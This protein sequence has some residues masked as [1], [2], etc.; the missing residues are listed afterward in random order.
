LPDTERVQRGQKV[1]CT[2]GGER[3]AGVLRG[4]DYAGR[5]V[6][7]DE[8]GHR[9]V[10]GWDRLEITGAEIARRSVLESLSVRALLRPPEKLQRALDA[11][12]ETEVVGPHRASEYIEAIQ[13]AG[14]EVFLTGGAIRDVVHAM[15]KHPNA[16]IEALAELLKD[17]DLATTA[18]PPVVRRICLEI[19]P[20]YASGAVWSPLG[21]DQFGSVL[22]GGPKAGLPNP[23]GLD[24]NCLRSEG[25][26]EEMAPH[27]D[28]GERAYPYTFDHSLLD[29][30]G[31]RDF[32]CNALYY[33]PRTKILVDP[34][35]HGLEDAEKK[36]LRISRWQTL[37]KDDNIALRFW[38]FRLRGYDADP[39]TKRTLGRQAKRALWK[40]PRW[41]VVLNV[42][43]VVPKDARTRE[44]VI[45]FL[46]KLAVVMRE[47]GAGDLYDR[48]I[49]PLAGEIARKIERRY[50][51]AKDGA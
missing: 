35:G 19:A 51:R 26:F 34:T 48:R 39:E 31:T 29:D 46:R 11:S 23:E 37:E 14:Y 36:T 20:E 24:I 30:A 18:P 27:A 44:D 22:V 45:A 4:F 47:D 33:D 6:I 9:R 5:P 17:I 2:I 43:R 32:T 40:M 15:A 41:K 13:R 21:V 10:G 49:H 8:A 16:T 12:L 50:A 1:A 42:A 3:I 38:K 28:T 7:H 25:A